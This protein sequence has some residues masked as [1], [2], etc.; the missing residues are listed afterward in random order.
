MVERRIFYLLILAVLFIAD[1]ASAQATRIAAI[2]DGA[3]TAYC[4]WV[5]ERWVPV[6]K[7]SSSSGVTIRSQLSKLR[8]DIRKVTGSKKR[9]L[10]K[11][12]ALYSSLEKRTKA[13]CAQLPRPEQ[14]LTPTPTPR[15]SATPRSTPTPLSCFLAGS[16]TAPGCFGIPPSL[17]GNIDRGAAYF[18]RNC[19][20]CHASRP[21][22]NYSRVKGAFSFVPQMAP[23]LPSDQ[24]LAD[25]VAYLNRF[26][27]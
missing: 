9:S 25:I 8:N 16:N 17:T 11:K 14:E 24:A 19:T 20:G 15:S 21:P 6:L 23:Y 18:Q 27:F 12:Q 2:E 10:Q 3:R 1:F 4:G 22:Y 5:D 13:T 26:N 7:K